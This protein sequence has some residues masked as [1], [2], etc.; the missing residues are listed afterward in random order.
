M[1]R[2]MAEQTS[3]PSDSG[4][5][6]ATAVRPRPSPP[7]ADRLPPWNVLLHNDDVNEIGHVVRTLVRLVHLQQETAV[8]RAVEAHERG[9]TLVATTHKEHAE[10]L[11]EQFASASLTATAEPAP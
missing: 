1:I 9:L 2:P 6:T 10:L 3:I 7:K 4:S 8:L 5:A 11:C